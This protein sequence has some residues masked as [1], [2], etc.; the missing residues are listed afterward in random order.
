MRKATYQE[1]ILLTE[2]IEKAEQRANFVI[3]LLNKMG[4]RFE[5]FY[6]DKDAEKEKSY[7]IT[8]ADVRIIEHELFIDDINVTTR[9]FRKFSEQLDKTWNKAF[10]ST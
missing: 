2:L 9:S 1:R 3:E 4:K 6:Y 10:P 7:Y 8:A 5:E